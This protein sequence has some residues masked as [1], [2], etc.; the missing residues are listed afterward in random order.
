MQK[1]YKWDNVH[2]ISVPIS[3]RN[4]QTYV[5]L[6][7]PKVKSMYVDKDE[8]ASGLYQ[9]AEKNNIELLSKNDVPFFNNSF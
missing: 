3:T 8:L 7:V 2:I 5:D 4:G 9:I 6:I 1:E